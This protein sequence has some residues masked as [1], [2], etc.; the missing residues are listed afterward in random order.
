MRL[1]FSLFACELWHARRHG[2]EPLTGVTYSDVLASKA[3]VGQIATAMANVPG[4]GNLGEA[5]VRVTGATCGRA[6]LVQ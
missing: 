2:S 6:V 4:L 3:T 5:D 1:E